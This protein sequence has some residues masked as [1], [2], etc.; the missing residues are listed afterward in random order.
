VKR[1]VAAL[2]LLAGSAVAA[3]TGLPVFIGPRAIDALPSAAP[4]ETIRYGAAPSQRIEFFHPSKPPPQQGYPVVVLIHGG[5]WKPGMEPAILRPM[6]AAMTERGFAVWSIGYRRVG[7]E[8]GGYPGTYLDVARAVDLVAEQAAERKLDPARVVLFGHSAGGQLALWAA[9]RV[10]IPA[11]SPLAAAH[12][13]RPRGV[14][15]AGG[16]GNLGQWGG[17]IAANCGAETAAAILAPGQDDARLA[18]TSPE[19]LLPTG[20]PSVLVHG[21]Y[22]PASFPAVGLAY[23]RAAVRAGDR[24]SIELAPNAAHFEPIAPGAR[25][26]AQ[27]ADAIERLAR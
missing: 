21:I 26:F 4:A 25:A 2:C 1:A 3:Q 9:G 15:A 11:G 6:A 12:A 5:C 27:V 17:L 16:F 14:V 10:R 22:D 20:V 18:D 8:G 23:V 24:S 7:E 19:H 13:L